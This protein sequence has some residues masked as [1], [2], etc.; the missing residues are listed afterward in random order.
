MAKLMTFVM[1]AVVMMLLLYLIGVNTTAGYIISQLGLADNPGNFEGSSIYLAVVAALVSLGAASAIRIGFFG[2]NAPDT[3]ASAG[4]AIILG[5]FIADFITV[6]NV[7]TTSCSNVDAC[8]WVRWVV[9]LIM[10]PIL[11]GYALSLFDWARGN[12]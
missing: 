8:G 4:L 5:A 2:V 11:V 10:G 9:I 3:F 7:A 6:I 1:T 12:D